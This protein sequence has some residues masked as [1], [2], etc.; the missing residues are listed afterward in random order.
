MI[1]SYICLKI[2][3]TRNDVIFDFRSVSLSS[4][5]CHKIQ[6]KMMRPQIFYSVDVA[7]IIRTF[8]PN[9]FRALQPMS[10]CIHFV[11]C[12]SKKIAAKR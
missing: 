5:C 10:L 11:S 4:F 6:K 9:I 7:S 1:K 2:H 12:A 3:Y 8:F